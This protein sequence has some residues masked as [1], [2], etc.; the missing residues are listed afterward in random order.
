MRVTDTLKA[1]WRTEWSSRSDLRPLEAAFRRAV[2]F[3]ESLPAYRSE[4]AEPGTLS[5][6]G[7]SD[8]VRTLAAEKVVPDL[9]RAAWEVEKTGN[10]LINERR[11]L[12]VQKP[13]KADVAGAI[14]RSEIRVFLRGMSQG[15]R[16]SAVMTDPEFLVAAFEGPAALSGFTNEVRAELEERL[17]RERHGDAVALMEDAREAISMTE[18]AINVALDV[19]RTETGFEGETR[20]FDAWMAGA[21]AEVEREIA[22]ERARSAPKKGQEEPAGNS[23]DPMRRIDEMFARLPVY[24]FGANGLE[25]VGTYGEVA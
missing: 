1:R 11:R 18:A 12:A 7:V 25:R 6:K 24:Q 4:V 5:P 17:I 15:D 23:G 9:R 21:C 3:A 13:D 14:L 8:A 22:A 2:H 19:L 10:G 16:I 20:G